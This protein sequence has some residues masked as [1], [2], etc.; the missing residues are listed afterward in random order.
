MY[1]EPLTP[2]ERDDR[3]TFALRVVAK[4]LPQFG[5]APDSKI[6]GLP[7]S[8][9]VVLRVTP[10]TG[11]PAVV[12]VSRQGSNTP[13]EIRSELA[14]I[15]AL[16][17]QSR[18]PVPEVLHTVDGESVLTLTDQETGEA[19]SISVF[20]NV[21]GHEPAE[22]ELLTVLPRL[23]RISAELHNHSTHWQRPSWFARKRWDLEA[24]FGPNSRWGDWRVGVTDPGQRTLIEQA[25]LV[26][27]E[28]LNAFGTGPERFGLIHADLRTANVL[29]DGSNI[30]VI[31][32]DDAGFGWWLYELAAA[33]TFY[34]N[35]PECDAMVE[36]WIKGYREVR[37]LSEADAREVPTF[38]VF[39]RLLTL[40]FLANNPDIAVS[41]EMLPG[42]PEKTADLSEAYLRRFS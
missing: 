39:R 27:R 42:L 37:Q 22:D 14:W 24:A 1:E 7:L 32:F 35:D 33:L 30:R 18:A 17:M 8:E 38:L 36:A 9:N 28:R 2:P 26:V 23:G 40:A 4:V 29:V 12:R 3:L 34:E 13:I 5:I 25:E 21:P 31:D 11:V 10:S 20:E 16:R 6:D 19:A 41:R 15:E